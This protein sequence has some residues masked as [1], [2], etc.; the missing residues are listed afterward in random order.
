MKKITSN[1]K[2][3]YFQTSNSQGHQTTGNISCRKNI[4][5][6]SIAHTAPGLTCDWLGIEFQGPYLF[7]IS[8]NNHWKLM[9]SL[10]KHNLALAI[11]L[12]LAVRKLPLR[13]ILCRIIFTSV[14]KMLTYCEITI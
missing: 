8:S 12:V 11:H 13:Q 6:L 4:F 14:L 5:L 9:F 7:P 2:H 1:I 3:A 10:K